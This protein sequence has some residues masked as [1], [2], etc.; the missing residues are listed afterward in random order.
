M[1]NCQTPDAYKALKKSKDNYSLNDRLNFGLMID[2][3]EYYKSKQMLQ[4]SKKY[5]CC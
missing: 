4:Y 1:F 2:E 3:D 5:N